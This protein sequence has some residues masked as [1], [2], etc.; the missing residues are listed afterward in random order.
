ME[1]TACHGA[2]TKPVIWEWFKKPYMVDLKVTTWKENEIVFNLRGSFRNN[3]R[4]HIPLSILLEWTGHYGGHW[5][6]TV[7]Y[8]LL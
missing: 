5:G 4:A 2:Y 3:D 1:S 8:Y 7:G 6:G